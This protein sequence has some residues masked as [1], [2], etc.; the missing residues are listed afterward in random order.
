L[1]GS[2]G[3]WNE[4]VQSIQKAPGASTANSGSEI[5][6]QRST[7]PMGEMIYRRH[8]RI[9]LKQSILRQN[10]IHNNEWQDQSSLRVQRARGTSCVDVHRDMNQQGLQDTVILNTRS[11]C[12]T[13]PIY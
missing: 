7:K 9:Q 12:Q 6:K 5:V 13:L 4:A 8:T 10:S 11:F 2:T 1:Y 3:K